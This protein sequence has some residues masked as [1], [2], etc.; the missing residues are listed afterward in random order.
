MVFSIGTKT[1]KNYKE[2]CDCRLC[3]EEMRSEPL[4]QAS[5]VRG[6]DLDSVV[7]RSEVIFLV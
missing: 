7:S 6:V 1:T 5:T 4:S 3:L 2:R